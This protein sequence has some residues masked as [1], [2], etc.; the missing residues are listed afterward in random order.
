MLH[1]P[2]DKARQGKARLGCVC[3]RVLAG[4]G[5]VVCHLSDRRPAYGLKFE[6]F[7]GRARA[8]AGENKA[9]GSDAVGS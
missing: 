4:V 1:G 2:G 9:A 8:R 7:S 5:V 3:G 6:P